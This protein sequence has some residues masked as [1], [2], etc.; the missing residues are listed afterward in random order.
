MLRG[1]RHRLPPVV[2]AAVCAVVTRDRSYNTAIAEWVDELPA[3]TALMVG[4][5]THRRPSER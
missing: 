1:V 2:S 3:A 4:I 5:D